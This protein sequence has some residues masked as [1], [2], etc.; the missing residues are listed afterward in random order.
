MP[1]GYHLTMSI[2]S[3]IE[4]GSGLWDEEESL[5][6]TTDSAAS[7]WE[8]LQGPVVDL[9]YADTNNSWYE[10]D[11]LVNS[12]GWNAVSIL[13]QPRLSQWRTASDSCETWPLI[14]AEE[15]LSSNSSKFCFTDYCGEDSGATALCHA[16]SMDARP[17]GPDFKYE[18]V[19]DA[20]TDKIK[21]SFGVYGPGAFVHYIPTQD[22]GLAESGM[23]ELEADGWIDESSR[24][25]SLELAIHSFS[26]RKLVYVRILIELPAE[27]G[28]PLAHPSY[29]TF[30]TFNSFHTLRNIMLGPRGAQYYWLQLGHDG[31]GITGDRLTFLAELALLMLV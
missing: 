14:L 28:V 4:I 9:V 5:F 29:V 26:G 31:G 24:A 25:V 11:T 8:W 22:R 23:E 19:P 7:I 10:G 27:G 1:H 6:G 30:S 17:F 12:Q 16:A 18:Y 3:A 15:E 2:R 13:G 21:G 20:H